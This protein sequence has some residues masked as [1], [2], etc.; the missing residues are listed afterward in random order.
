MYMFAVVRNC[1]SWP[2]SYLLSRWVVKC[3]GKVA[4]EVTLKGS[5]KLKQ[6]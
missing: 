6:C 5:V 1:L 4:V 3:L 2:G